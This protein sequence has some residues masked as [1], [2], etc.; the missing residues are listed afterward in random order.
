MRGQKH[1]KYL[2]GV[3][4]QNAKCLHIHEFI[5]VGT[6]AVC[7]E[8]KF[9][10]LMGGGLQIQGSSFRIYYDVFFLF[11]FSDGLMN[12]AKVIPTG[13]RKLKSKW[14]K[15]SH[16]KYIFTLCRKLWNKLRH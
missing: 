12:R 2:K 9:D 4:A 11:F 7:Q 14:L 8:V 3:I 16:I 13:H 6:C 5:A 15:F 10:T 1:S